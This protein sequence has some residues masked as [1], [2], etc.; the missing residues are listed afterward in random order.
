M[1]SARRMDVFTTCAIELLPALRIAAMLSSDCF[2][3]ATTSLLGK[4][5]VCSGGRGK[6]S[7]DA[8]LTGA[9]RGCN[10]GERAVAN[11]RVEAQ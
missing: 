9:L 3:C 2:V 10:A 5:P 1:M 6:R 7:A 11:L 4:S 8:C